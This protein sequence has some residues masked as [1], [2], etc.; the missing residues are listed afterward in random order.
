MTCNNVIDFLPRVGGGEATDQPV[1]LDF[2]GETVDDDDNEDVYQLTRP[3][4]D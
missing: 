2:N 4:L 3:S 1:E